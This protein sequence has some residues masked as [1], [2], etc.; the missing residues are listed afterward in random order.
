VYQL[1]IKSG[2]D[3]EYFAGVNGLAFFDVKPFDNTTFRR[4]DFVLHLHRFHDDEALAGLDFVSR[5]DKDAN[6]FAWHG[7]D[8]LLA[9]LGFERAMPAAPPGP[10]IRNLGGEFLEAD[11]ELQHTVQ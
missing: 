11:L 8:Y 7:S 9:A 2:N 3:A 1:P 6:N 5:F 10:R 4:T